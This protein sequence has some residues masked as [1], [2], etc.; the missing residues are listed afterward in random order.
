MTSAELRDPWIGHQPGD[1]EFVNLVPGAARPMMRRLGDRDV[2]WIDVDQ[3]GDMVRLSSA[4]S[5][6]IE[7]GLIAGRDVGLPVVLLLSSA[8][9]D[10]MEGMSALDAWG[11][12]PRHWPAVPVACRRSPSSMV[13][14]SRD[15]HC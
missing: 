12:S 5:A 7:C 2:I 11:A 4:T 1:L 14:P 9:A 10:I 15:R 13:P 8:G 3:P 6:K